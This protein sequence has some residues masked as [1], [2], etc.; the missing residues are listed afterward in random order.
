[1]PSEPFQVCPGT[2]M[3]T[4]S[5]VPTAGASDV[6]EN[7]LHFQKNDLSD[8]GPSEISALTTQFDAWRGT[9]DGTNALLTNHTSAHTLVGYTARDLSVDGGPEYTNAVS[10][11]GLDAGAPLSSGLSK[12]LT[13]RTGLSGKS[14]RGRIFLSGLTA[15]LTGTYGPD[16]CDPAVLGAIAAAWN[17]LITVAAG[18]TPACKWTVLSRKHKV[19]SIPNVTRDTGLNTPVTAVSYS[20]TVIDFQRRRAPLHGRHN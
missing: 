16:A 12:A 7:V 9:S 2:A 11:A 5:Y 1:M 6:L 10:H 18:W 20:S 8:W 17:N 15:T 4:V 14:F 13:L 19:G 3:F